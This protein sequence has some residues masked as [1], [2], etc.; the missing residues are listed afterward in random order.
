MCVI[1]HRRTILRV[2][3]PEPSIKAPFLLICLSDVSNPERLNCGG[4]SP[5]GSGPPSAAT[6]SSLRRLDRHR[7]RVLSG[8]H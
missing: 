5:M 4:T 2:N 3:G 8:T 7:W 6:P 1:V